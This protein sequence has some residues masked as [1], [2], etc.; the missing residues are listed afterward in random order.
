MKYDAIMYLMV[1]KRLH[2]Y[3]LTTLEIHGFP[4]HH[5]DLLGHYAFITYTDDNVAMLSQCRAFFALAGVFF[6]IAL[7]CLLFGIYAIIFFDEPPEP[8][9]SYVTKSEDPAVEMAESTTNTDSVSETV[10]ETPT[11]IPKI[12]IKTES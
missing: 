2:A 6:G 11:D 4:C 1:G 5:F 12:T 10:E 3:K 8:R 9:D 7:F